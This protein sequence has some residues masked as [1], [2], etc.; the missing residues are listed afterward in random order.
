MPYDQ[1]LTK[2]SNSHCDYNIIVHITIFICNN[3]MLIRSVVYYGMYWLLVQFCYVTTYVTF[4]MCFSSPKKT[5]TC[6]TI[7]VFVFRCTFF[8]IKST[9]FNSNAKNIIRERNDIVNSIQ[10]LIYLFQFHSYAIFY[11]NMVEKKIVDQL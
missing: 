5:T 2:I 7:D 3:I 9:P 4:W 8:H 6:S 11:S 10:S 1:S